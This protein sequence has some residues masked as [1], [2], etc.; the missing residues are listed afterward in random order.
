MKEQYVLVSVTDL[1]FNDVI[2]PEEENQA[3]I[4][5]NLRPGQEMQDLFMQNCADLGIF[6][7]I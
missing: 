2:M 4:S 6:V 1:T 3:E 7:T 5:A